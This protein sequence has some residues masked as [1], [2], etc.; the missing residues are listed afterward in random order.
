[1]TTDR[2]DQVF[3]PVLTTSP[4][5]HVLTELQLHGY[6]PFQDEPDPRL[7]PEARTVA[8]AVADIFDALIA[9]LSDTRLEPDLENLLW[10]SVNLFHRA[11]ER[12]ERELD[13]N[14]LAQKRSQKDQDGS[15]IR[16]V[17]LERLIAEGMTLIERRNAI[18]LFRELAIEQFETHTGSLWRPRSGSLVDH[19]AVTAAII[20]SRDFLAAKRRADTEVLVPVGPKIALTGGLDFDDYHLI[21]DRLD[22]VHGKHPDMVLLHGGSPKGAELIAAKWATNRKVPQVA[23]RPDWTKHAKA[24]PFK[25]NDL[26]LTLMPIGV[27]VFPGTGIQDN[28]ADKARKLGIPV[29]QFGNGGA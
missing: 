1:M 28:L 20:D 18:E 6:R 3:D 8:N 19:R 21:W 10:G 15:E 23:F 25:R 12:I 13:G 11:T 4:T 17:E 9:T 7:L 16:S 14:E 27:M 22:K 24:A 5:D 2:D 26:M 29:W